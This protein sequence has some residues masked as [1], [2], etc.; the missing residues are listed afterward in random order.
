M[1]TNWFHSDGAVWAPITAV[2]AYSI[3]FCFL[4]LCLPLLCPLV[5]DYQ[6]LY[7]CG[8]FFAILRRQ[9]YGNTLIFLSHYKTLSSCACARRYTEFKCDTLKMRVLEI[10]YSV[11]A[12]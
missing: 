12:L 9:Y 4:R 10:D 1:I 2:F 7:K 8:K 6:E 3:V 5:Y 11:Y